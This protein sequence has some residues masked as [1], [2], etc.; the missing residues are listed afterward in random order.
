MRRR[1]V[2]SVVVLL[3]LG[4]ASCGDDDDGDDQTSAAAGD[5]TETTAEG[6]TE[7]TEAGGT[8]DGAEAATVAVADTDLGQ[9]LVDGDGMTLYLFTRDTAD[10]SA[11]TGSCAESWPP[12][13]A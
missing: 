3:T 12:L 13:A 6:D 8:G 2:L 5:T 7:T 4:L 9:V 11:C 1:A 10:A